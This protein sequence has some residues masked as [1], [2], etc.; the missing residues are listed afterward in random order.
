MQGIVG[1]QKSISNQQYATA[2]L[3]SLGIAGIDVIANPVPGGAYF[4][5]RF[6]HNSSSNPLTNGD[7]YTRMT[8]YIA[9]TLNAG[10]GKFVGLPQAANAIGVAGTPSANAQATLGTF[11]DNLQGQGLIG[12]IGGPIAYS[13]QIDVNNNPQSRVALGYLQADVA[14]QYQSIIEKFLINTA[15]GTS[16]QIQRVGVSLI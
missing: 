8:N 5:A 1:T 6:G 15:G 10:M 3:Q 11:F 9:G 16:V 4:G 12:A 7:N 14:V 2:D 13:V